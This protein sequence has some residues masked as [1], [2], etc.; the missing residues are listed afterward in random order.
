MLLVLPPPPQLQ[1]S[2]SLMFP[3][4]KTFGVKTLFFFCGLY[5][6]AVFANLCLLYIPVLMTT[7]YPSVWGRQLAVYIFCVF[8][9][10]ILFTRCGLVVRT[11]YGQ[12]CSS[13][14]FWVF[15]FSYLLNWTCKYSN[16]CYSSEGKLTQCLGGLHKNINRIISCSCSS[17]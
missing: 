11:T 15:F 3:I 8:R 17:E 12:A 6:W 14:M 2:S 5:F 7:V 13:V 9:N 1:N 10:R 16:C 4:V